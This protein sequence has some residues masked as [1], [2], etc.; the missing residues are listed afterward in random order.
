M[1]A[2]V[3]DVEA[4]TRRAQ[5][6]TSSNSAIKTRYPSAKDGAAQPAE[7]F[8]DTAA[9]AQSIVTARMALFGVE[10]RRFT[11]EVDALQFPPEPPTIRRI[12]LT[13][14][15]QNCSASPMLTARIELDL[16]AE[17]TNYEVFG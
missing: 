4:G 10:T 5:I 11:I 2:L 13:D 7:G 16:E 17:R 12:A 14:P 15:E 3:S 8:F 1:P 9:D 6:E